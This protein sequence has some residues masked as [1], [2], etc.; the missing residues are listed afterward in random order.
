MDSYKTM[1]SVLNNVFTSFGDRLIEW[2]EAGNSIIANKID[3]VLQTTTNH[4]QTIS[5]NMQS[6][7]INQMLNIQPIKVNEPNG[8]DQKE[9]KDE[10]RQQQYYCKVVW[11]RSRS[12]RT[13]SK[14]RS[15]MPNCCITPT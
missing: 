5:S 10:Q 2:M 11:Y 12:L 3:R 1:N 14:R 7:S 6:N 13:K 4:Q 15:A 9:I 8:D